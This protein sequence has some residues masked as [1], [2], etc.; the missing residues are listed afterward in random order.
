MSIENIYNKYYKHISNILQ[1]GDIMNF[2][3]GPDYTDILEHVD[4]LKGNEYFNCIKTHT[5]I[6]DS[7]IIEYCK[8]NDLIGNGAKHNFNIIK[9]SPSNFRYL[10]HAHLIL[11]HMNKL[12]IDEVNIVEIG[13]GYGGLCMALHQLCELYKIKIKTYNLIDLPAVCKLQQ[14]YLSTHH[15]NVNIFSAFNHGEDIITC[16]NFLISNYSFSEIS[17]DNQAKYVSKLFKKIDHGFF[18]WNHIPVY[19]FGFS[20]VVE[21][22]YPLTAK[23]NKYVYF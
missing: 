5:D 3:S 14:I 23:S 16:N 4:T 19:D 11:N 15:I 12:N 9:T 13:G 22:E 20:C 17:S 18:V 1:S 2:K 10:F 21:D 6:Q 7:A 8:K